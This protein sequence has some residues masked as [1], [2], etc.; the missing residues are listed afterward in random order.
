M[1][2]DYSYKPH[3]L[4]FYNGE[5]YDWVNG[6]WHSMTAGNDR[7]TKLRAWLYRDLA[8]KQVKH[9]RPD[10]TVEIRPFNPDKQKLMKIIDALIPACWVNKTPPC[11]LD[12]KKPDH[13]L[14]NMVI[15]QNGILDMA[16]YMKG[17]VNMTPTSRAFF[18]LTVAPYNFDPA[19]KCP[20][21]LQFLDEIFK[22]DKERI[23]LLQEWF[24]Y[25]MVYDT[26]LE[27]FIL[28][29]GR[30]ASGK[31]TV[32]NV[33]RE[34]VGPKN[35]GSSTF[36]D[37]CS[38]F[39]LQPLLNKSS[40]ILPDAHVPKQVDAVQALERIK[41]IVGR[42]TVLVNRKHLSLLPDA[43][44][45]GRFTVVVNELPRLP[46]HG[47]ALRR[48]LLLLHFP[49]TFEGREDYTLKDCLVKEV[50]GV[51][52]WALAGLRR[53]RLKCK[54]T[55]VA[56]SE[57]IFKDLCHLLTPLTEF[58]DDCCVVKVHSDMWITKAQLY[59]AWRM[60]SKEQ[61]QS[62]GSRILF[63]RL[64][65]QDSKIQAGR[66]RVGGR[67]V[68]VYRNLCLTKDAKDRYLAQV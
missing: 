9:R 67:L 63:G 34:T 61:G 10:G 50:Q 18:N 11:W 51:A 41:T 35:C 25:N 5:W 55:H 66:K 3:K 56:S 47:R 62:P 2:V 53:L 24:G 38:D 21:W 7:D 59:N 30:P 42:D 64:L 26:T 44:L 37:L 54:F 65:A 39:G 46:D 8:N 13:D 52:V 6:A 68:T 20:N 58:L 31:S 45:P 22:S 1:K 12:P 27:K 43:L 60:W 4:R 19:A 48:R 14:R 28:F 17:E 40:I 29:I 36:K 32:L 23:G 33:F 15:F 57:I 16:A 49:E